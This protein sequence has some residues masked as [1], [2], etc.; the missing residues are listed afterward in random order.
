[1]TPEAQSLAE[2]DPP[3]RLYRP[4]VWTSP[5]VFAS[6]HSGNIYPA[7]FLARALP[8][9]Q[10]LRRNEDIY[11]DRLFKPT[12]RWGAPLLAARFPRCFVDVNRAPGELPGEWREKTVPGTAGWKTG[13]VLCRPLYPGKYRFIKSR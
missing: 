6:P 8:N 13:W 9:L 7:S 3:T 12:S 10:D 1:M 5:V 4:K 11:I 2:F